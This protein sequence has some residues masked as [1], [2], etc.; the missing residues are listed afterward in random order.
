MTTTTQNN[1]NAA[2][3]ALLPDLRDWFAGMAPITFADAQAMCGHTAMPSTNDVDLAA[4]MAVLAKLR[5]DYADAMLAARSA[6]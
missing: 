2:P 1:E 5:Y 3:L 4:V 6:K